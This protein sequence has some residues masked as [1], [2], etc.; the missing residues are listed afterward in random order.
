MLK[1]LI[2]KA[3]NQSKQ[4]RDKYAFGVALGFTGVIALVWLYHAPSHIL[5][6]ASEVG[7]GTQPVADM[8]GQINSQM[9]NVRESVSTETASSSDNPDSWSTPEEW[10]L[11]QARNVTNVPATTTPD[12]FEASTTST[13]TQIT[14]G[15]NQTTPKPVRIITTNST[16]TATTST[17]QTP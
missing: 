9:A 2:V 6:V 11:R 4:T 10:A 7:G 15:S 13:S 1:R 17:Q 16:T 5:K 14:T 8:F 12:T 3:R